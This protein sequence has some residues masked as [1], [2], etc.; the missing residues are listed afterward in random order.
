[1]ARKNGC[2]FSV[3]DWEIDVRTRASTN[4]SPTWLRVKGAESIELSM[5]AETEDGSSGQSLYA[6]P[7]VTKR[8]GSL[9]LSVKRIADRVTGLRDPG[10]VEIEYYATLGGCDA[11][12]RI[13]MVDAVGNATMID[14]VITGVGTSADDSSESVDYDMEIVGEPIITPYVQLSS[15]ATLPASTV[16]VAVGATSEVT[17]KYTPA[18]A[19]NRKFSVVTSDPA[20]A[21]ITAVD[22]DKFTVMGLKAGTATLTI[23]SMNNARTATLAVTVTG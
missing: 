5:D 22:G 3:K 8:S 2:P 19:T 16:S 10:Q 9:T 17:V 13:R 12:A 21:T 6:E 15:I 4:E 23:K 11:D 18:N 20:T 7:Y 1:M 14:V